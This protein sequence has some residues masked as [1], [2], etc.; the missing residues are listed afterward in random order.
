[1]IQVTGYQVPTAPDSTF[2]YWYG[3]LVFLGSFVKQSFLVHDFYFCL[4]YPCSGFVIL[5]KKIVCEL[6]GSNEFSRDD[7]G[8]FVCDYCRTKYSAEQAKSMMV[9]GVVRIDK[10]ADIEP[11]LKIARDSLTSG[12]HEEGLLYSN[13]ILEIDSESAEAYFIKGVSLGRSSTLER[14]R[15]EEMSLAFQRAIEFQENSGSS[16]VNQVP[17]E[18]W[19]I[20][21]TIFNAA[22]DFVKKSEPSRAVWDT[23]FA[24]AVNTYEHMC[25]S[26]GE[27]VDLDDK[28]G[29]LGVLSA[30]IE[31]IDAIFAVGKTRQNMPSG[32]WG[33]GDWGASWLTSEQISF[34][35]E[36]RSNAVSLVKEIDP[37]KISSDKSCFI[38]SASVG[39]NDHFILDTLREFRDLIL[40]RSRV[41]SDFISWYYR[42]GP[43]AAIY[44]RRYLLLRTFCF[45]L[46]VLPSYSIALLL[47][48]CQ[49]SFN[50]SAARFPILF[51]SRGRIHSR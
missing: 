36:Q 20:S 11:L 43:L 16:F 3:Q 9:E 38:A 23:F 51:S 42:W 8:L 27:F 21:A 35:S 22:I 5:M 1:V 50:A 19:Q 7:E 4:V 32:N 28:E 12:N 44:V 46:V 18:R 24:V 13:R 33:P 30:S 37:E 26:Y 45:G 34:W 2:C 39:S 41:G 15:L 40:S 47:L 14:L 31:F 48:S 25:L 29:C 10:T 49:K 17:K 6:C